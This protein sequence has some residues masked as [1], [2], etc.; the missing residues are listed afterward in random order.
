MTNHFD[1]LFH[2]RVPNP[3]R[4]LAVSEVFALRKVTWDRAF[5]FEW[6]LEECVADAELAQDAFIV[7]AGVGDHPETHVGHCMGKL[8]CELLLSTWFVEAREIDL[9]ERSPVQV[10][11]SWCRAIPWLDQDALC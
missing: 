4:V 6:F 8:F 9:H 11:V 7:D 5:F 2:A 1:V 10:F 3:S